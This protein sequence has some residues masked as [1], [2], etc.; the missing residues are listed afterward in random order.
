M[1]IDNFVKAQQFLYEHIPKK[2]AKK[3]PG[4]LGL[5]RTK[6]FLKLL[7]NPQ[8]KLKVIHIA[9][10]SG[11]GSTA[12]LTSLL[13]E[14]LG[15]KVGLYTS[16]HLVDIRERLQIGNKMISKQDFVSCLNK[17]IPIFDK[18]KNSKFGEPTYF[19]ILAAMAFYLFWKVRVDYAVVETGMGGLY[20]A[21]NIVSLQ[22]KLCILTKIGLD[23]MEILGDTIEKIARQKAK[24]IQGKN[25]TISI[26]QEFPIKQVIDQEAKIKHASL[27]Y[28]QK[29]KDFK[30]IKVDIKKT[31]F[32]FYPRHP[33]GVRKLTLGLIGQHQV[34]N[35]SLALTAVNYLSNRDKFR[36]DLDKIRKVLKKAKFPGRFEVKK[37]KNKT[38]VVDGAHNQQKMEA[39]IKTLKE[40]FPNTKFH[41]LVAFKKDKNYP[42]MLKQI[43]PFASKITITS[44]YLKQD[45]MPK[46]HDPALI[47]K[48][49]SKLGFTN[50]Q[51]IKNPKQALNAVLNVKQKYI[52]TTGSLYLIAKLYSNFPS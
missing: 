36:F 52:A 22:D 2:T 42:K 38:V 39:F 48:T 6:Y 30:N 35:A 24:I 18:V 26:K 21:T 10:T 23:H 1:K 37:I 3:F 5:E 9:G 31:V 15:L 17:I 12:Y 14:S 16:P 47:A 50:Y 49:L 28:L 20:D 29:S 46:S 4:E 40:V 41:F 7:G 13:L 33:E 43:I 51:I 45:I 11:K 25:H 44:F 34:E 32:D 19:E 8:N 27:I